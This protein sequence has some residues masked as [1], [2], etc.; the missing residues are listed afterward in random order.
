M[1]YQ[2][3]SNLI[4]SFA[5]CA[6]AKINTAIVSMME[7]NASV[8]SKFRLMHHFFSFFHTEFLF[9]SDSWIKTSF[10]ILFILLFFSIKDFFQIYFIIS[11]VKHDWHNSID[12]NHSESLLLFYVICSPAPI[13]DWHFSQVVFSVFLFIFFCLLR[14]IF[15][16]TFNQYYYDINFFDKMSECWFWLF[17]FF[18]I[19]FI[20][21]FSYYSIK[22][23]ITGRK[24]ERVRASAHC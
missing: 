2:T 5:Y 6:I 19:Q 11:H 20:H 3:C 16:Q 4:Y 1:A 24:C 12:W 10:E 18:F 21:W 15:S 14:T 17:S 22:L 8:R 13:N 7:L 23:L 9:P